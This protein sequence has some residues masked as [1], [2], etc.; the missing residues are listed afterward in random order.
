MMPQPVD[1][2]ILLPVALR[3]TAMTVASLTHEPARHSFAPLRH[4]CSAQVAR[5]RDEMTSAGHPLDVIE[6]AL[7]AQCALL[8]ETALR[9]LTGDD[10]TAWE[11]EPL[12]VEAFGRNDA[13]HEVISR[14]E[15]R[16]AEPRPVLP[17]LAIF[18]AIL[19]L[20]FAGKLALGE[21]GAHAAL[22]NAI[23]ERL[24]GKPDTHLPVMIDDVTACRPSGRFGPFS[25]L[26]LS[27]IMGGMLYLALNEWL[28]RSVAEI[29]Q[30]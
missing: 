28:G 12:Q 4:S 27:F 29:V 20:G 26:A 22:L 23:D 24:G 6:D 15:H 10:R 30:P 19:D 7:Y 14:I 11:R 8:D 18:R 21:R 5:L 1:A 2:A 25:W 3:D 9:N 17:L 16:V 13:G